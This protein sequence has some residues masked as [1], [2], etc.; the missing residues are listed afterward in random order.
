MQ[1]VYNDESQRR[2]KNASRNFLT[3]YSIAI[4]TPRCD[5]LRRELRVAQFFTF[6]L[7]TPFDL[8][9]NE[10]IDIFAFSSSIVHN[11]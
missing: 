8:F 9:K 1:S 11:L 6:L 7:F 2:S 5:W 4:I 10:D 3:A